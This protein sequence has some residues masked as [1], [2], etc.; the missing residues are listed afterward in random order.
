M[1]TYNLDNIKHDALSGVL[2][3]G[4]FKP[5]KDFVSDSII[6]GFVKD[7][8]KKIPIPGLGEIVASFAKL[9]SGCNDDYDKEELYREEKAKIQRFIEAYKARA[10]DTG[11]S[12]DPAKRLEM[13]DRFYSYVVAHHNYRFGIVACSRN[14]HAEAIK[15]EASAQFLAN[16]RKQLS[17]AYILRDK[18]EYFADG[19]KSPENK[20]L[21]V[22]YKTYTLRSDAKERIEALKSSGV[23]VG[24]DNNTLPIIP[25]Q[26]PPKTEEKTNFGLIALVLVIVGLVGAG[27][28]AL[29]QKVKPKKRK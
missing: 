24:V 23:G 1:L 5:V 14:K 16:V 8:A 15:K 22:T 4:G 2:G 26:S 7:I 13:A 17:V 11:Y 27:V 28:T 20:M 10:N 9:I 25:P 21:N 6:P 12:Q 19:Y 3:T 18:T 29:V